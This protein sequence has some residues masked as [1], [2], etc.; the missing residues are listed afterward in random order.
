[1]LLLLIL[2]NIYSLIVNN[3]QIVKTNKRTENLKSDFLAIDQNFQLI[4]QLSV[5]FALNR[6]RHYKTRHYG[7]RHYRTRHYRTYTYICNR[8]E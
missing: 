1:M 3:I 7:T 5:N 2:C 8:A 6:T 4:S